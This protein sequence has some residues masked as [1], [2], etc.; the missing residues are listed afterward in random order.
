MSV[1]VKELINERNLLVL[2][3]FAPYGA[4]DMSVPM[5][6]ES[7]QPIYRSIEERM[8]FIYEHAHQKEFCLSCLSFN[9][10]VDNPNQINSHLFRNSGLIL[11]SG[12]ITHA[13]EDD[14][15]FSTSIKLQYYKQHHIDNLKDILDKNVLNQNRKSYNELRVEYP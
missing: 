4:N 11:N 8:T 15:G 5:N 12:L 3:C 6:G 2:H 9:L 14:I 10:G 1:N 7:S 13:S